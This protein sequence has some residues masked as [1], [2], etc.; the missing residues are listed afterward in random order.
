MNKINPIFE[1]LSNVDDRHI[2]VAHE[3]R[4][5]IKPKIILVAAAVVTALALAG[6]TTSTVQKHMFGFYGEG[7]TE[8]SFE[9]KLTSHEIIVPKEFMPKPDEVNFSQSTDIPPSELFE[10]FGLKSPI[11]DN[12]TEVNEQSTVNVRM[13]ID[14]STSVDDVEFRY[15]LFNKSIDQN[16]IFNARYYSGPDNMTLTAREGLL[17][18]EPNEVITLKDGSLCM[19]TKS[20]AVF[21]YDGAEFRF[22]IDYDYEVPADIGEMT[23]EEQYRVVDE[24]IEAMPGMDAVKQVLADLG[25]L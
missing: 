15:T 11:N 2:P 19:I 13:D 6:F 8:H 14:D 1:A 25:L 12:F 20:K 9:F 10:M 22:E 3:K 24:M 5:A 4:P 16:V 7:V 23:E 21:S 17:P 18:N